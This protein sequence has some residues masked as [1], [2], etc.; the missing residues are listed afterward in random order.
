MS[1]PSHPSA[2]SWLHR[3]CAPEKMLPM[4]SQSPLPVLA[5]LPTACGSAA[6]DTLGDGALVRGTEVLG[7]GGAVDQEPC[8]LHLADG[9]EGHQADVGLGEGLGAGLH[10]TQD[11]ACSKQPAA[12]HLKV[13]VQTAQYRCGSSTA[14]AA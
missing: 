4:N 5:L 11:L 7:G 14:N 3:Q 9:I 8:N 1:C 2:S 6:R 10:L 13:Q 12:Q